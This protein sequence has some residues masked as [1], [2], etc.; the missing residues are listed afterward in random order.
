MK[1]IF[2]FILL[3]FSISFNSAY[4]QN[5]FNA[6]SLDAY[7][8]AAADSLSV[9]GLAVGI[10]KDSVFVFAKGYGLTDMSNDEAVN[11][12]TIFLI[13]SCSKAFT[14]A[15]IAIL[16]DEGKLDWDDKVVDHLPEFQLHDPY[17][18]RELRISDLLTHRSGLATFDG[19]LLWYGTK[20][21]RAEVVH[22]IR[23]LP[24]KNSLR[25]KFGYSNLMYITAGEV[26]KAVTGKSWDEFIKDKIFNPI[27]M[28]RTSTLLEEKINLDNVAVPHLQ[29]K[30]MEFINYDNSGPAATIN[31]T[32]KDLLKW[33]QMWLNGGMV[34]STQIISKA[35][36]R[37]VTSSQT[38]LDGGAGMEKFG[39]HFRDY[40]MGWF[41]MDYSGK[42][43]IWHDGGMPGYLAR[44]AWIPE[45]NLGFVI[46][47]NDMTGIV[48]PVGYKILDMFLNDKNEDYIGQAVSRAKRVEKFQAKQKA[49][50][51]SSRM[52][53]TTPSLKL[54]DYAGTYKDKM[55]GEAEIKFEDGELTLTMLPTKELFT[56][57]MEHWHH[58]TFR[59]KF[60]DPFLP[61]GFVT[62][63]FDSN[64]KAKS[65]TIDL[66]NGDFHFYNLK[67]ER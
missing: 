30:P 26:I 22:R 3:I 4:S 48:N 59:I 35:S 61:E 36:I 46:L 44:V 17:V 9:P 10:I 41:L 1:K 37:K 64:G 19:D 53:D 39:T 16:V 14:A 13:A 65:F 32:V 27:G 6:D 5:N 7:I 62:F 45:D 60:N 55:Y 66:P 31:S 8:Q 49:D 18:T 12:E 24:L 51:D 67:F 33:I 28:A 42:K 50:R 20:Y 63:A 47:T 21:D 43:V 23:E 58:D 29:K 25:Y 11:G 57:K 38:V 52:M 56:S 40:G 34:D 54:E 2:P 15:A